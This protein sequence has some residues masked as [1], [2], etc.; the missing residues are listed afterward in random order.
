[1]ILKDNCYNIMVLRG[2]NMCKYLG[3]KIEHNVLN[4]VRQ[5]D[6]STMAI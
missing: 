5:A 3:I 4:D 1:M 6:G 2:H